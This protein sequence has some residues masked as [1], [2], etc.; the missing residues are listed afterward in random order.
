MGF[1]GAVRDDVEFQA[2][3]REL[4]KFIE[5]IESEI[6]LKRFLVSPFLSQRK[7]L[8]VLD[9]V[10]RLLGTGDKTARL[11]RLLVEHKRFEIVRDVAQAL[12]EAWDEKRGVLAFEVISAVPLSP[13]QQ[14]RLRSRLELSERNPVRLTFR[15]EPSV[16]G[17]VSLKR[18]QVIRDATLE[19]NLD[20]L[21]RIIHQG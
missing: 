18:G 9:D 12:P 14:E 2:V 15:V 20:R 1:V 16:L 6:E 21:R 19:S 4:G 5:T 11:L 17:G 8:E 7:K 13:E 10:V 3:S